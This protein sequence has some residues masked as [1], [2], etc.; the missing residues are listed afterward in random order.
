M[1]KL[2]NA[3]GLHRKE[4]RAWAM[5]DWANSAFQ[6]TVIAAVFPRFFA[7]YASAGVTPTEAAARFA[8]ISTAAAVVVAVLGP[9]LGAIADYR[10]AKKTLLAVAMVIGVIATASM[11]LITKGGWQFAAATFAIGNIAIAASLVFYDSMLPHIASHEEIDRVSTA[12]YA[13]GY[14]GGGLLLVVNLV[15]ILSPHTFG[16]ADAAAATKLSFFS[17]AVWWL[18]FS[19][20]LF[21]YVHEPPA[22][23]GAATG[24]NVVTVGFRLAW[25]TLKELRTYPNALLMLTAFLLYGDGI[26]TM[27]KMSSIYGAEA[28][29]DANAQIAAF[30]MVQ[31]VGIPFSFLFGWLAD[32]IGAKPAL[33]LSIAVYTVVSVIGYFLAHTWQFFLLAFL[34]GTVQGGSQALS[35]SLFAKMIPKEKSSEYFGFFSVFEKFGMIFG[36]AVFAVT[37]TAFGSSR[38]A[39]LSVIL[40]FILGALVLTRVDVAAGE[41]EAARPL[42]GETGTATR[43]PS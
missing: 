11:A 38:T 37:V 41:A 31:F 42:R 28:N 3:L 1:A 27:I 14:V 13:I 29:I 5:Y 7:D 15:W 26:Q 21:R 9:V 6:C 4:L 23:T 18:V 12:G 17:V 25:R 16:L 33:F 32:R 36:P 19:L 43:I 34:V 2:L 30:V 40:F 35:R 8:W 22:I 39:V 24:V 10:A 20:P